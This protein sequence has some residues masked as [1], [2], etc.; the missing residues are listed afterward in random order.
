MY[1]LGNFK[2]KSIYFVISHYNEVRVDLS[3]LSCHIIRTQT[4]CYG[5]RWSSHTKTSY[6]SYTKVILAIITK[7]WQ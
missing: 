3:A 6:N 2:D 4:S 7:T 5:E 1:A